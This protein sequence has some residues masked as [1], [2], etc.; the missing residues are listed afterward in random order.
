MLYT[1]DM[2]EYLLGRVI[3]CLS[4]YTFQEGNNLSEILNEWETM[5]DKVISKL[6]SFVCILVIKL[7]EKYQ[8]HNH[9]M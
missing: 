6:N 2:D 4:N 8:I 9:V 3:L 1:L 5:M 7:E